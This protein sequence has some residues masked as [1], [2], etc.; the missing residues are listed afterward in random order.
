MKELLRL[1]MIALVAIVG[2][3][4][5]NLATTLDPQSYKVSAKVT[6]GTAGVSYPVL[7]LNIEGPDGD[8]SRWIVTI[9]VE[10]H[11]P[12][13]GVISC[14]EPWQKDLEFPVFDSPVKDV[15]VLVTVSN[16]WS[17]TTIMARAVTAS[18]HE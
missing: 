7:Q 6:D 3:N 14:G 18:T 16:M 4:A 1:I 2:F 12:L 9:S 5:C 17:G 11:S 10:G 8:S 15:E 13:T